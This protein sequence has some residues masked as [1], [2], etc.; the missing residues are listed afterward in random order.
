[1]IETLK[2]GLSGGSKRA[3]DLYPNGRLATVVAVAAA[4]TCDDVIADWL[5]SQDVA[6][7][8]PLVYPKRSELRRAEARAASKRSR[9]S[10]AA[11]GSDRR[12]AG[13]RPPAAGGHHPRSAPPA[14]TSGARSSEPG[15][16]ASLRMGQHSS[17]QQKGPFQ[18]PI[19]VA[20][21][22][23][24]LPIPHTVD[25]ARPAGITLPSRRLARQNAFTPPAQPAIPIA[26]PQQLAP[27]PPVAPPEL[28]APGT[29]VGLDPADWGDRPQ[30]ETGLRPGRRRGPDDAR[31]AA[32]SQRAAKAGIRTAVRGKAQAARLLVLALV[33]GAEGVA[34]TSL[35]GVAHTAKPAVSA[36]GAT[37]TLALS[38]TLPASAVLDDAAQRQQSAVS[39]QA[40][41]FAQAIA[42]HESADSKYAAALGQAEAAAAR[43]KAAA[44]RRARAMRNVQRDPKSVARIL[45]AD[46]GWSGQ[47][48]CLD[49][50]W[51]RE[52]GWN[53]QAMNPSSG[54]YGIPQALP[55]SKMAS[56]GADWRTNPVTQM[57][58]GLDYIASRYGTP[59]AAWG[60]SQNTGWY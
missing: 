56:A 25:S 19:A 38:Q 44:E 24:V 57:R 51:T 7:P 4:G 27:A 43:I 1:M 58:W 53:Y 48:G 15:R 20:P 23:A 16:R 32:R 49:S 42:Q 28:A 26:V 55:G 8:G 54:A 41:A 33:V 60:H 52:S 47:F 13:A 11:A 22:P 6:P 18:L 21:T 31:P 40:D 29:I 39:A 34:M 17:G 37:G 14:P 50:L 35:A 45:L 3:R 30:D 9:G 59:C 36:E 10:S 12:P 5:S 46:R 2:S